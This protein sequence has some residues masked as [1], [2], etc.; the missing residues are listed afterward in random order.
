MADNAMETRYRQTWS[1][2]ISMAMPL[3][4]SLCMLPK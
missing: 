3:D 4:C 2:V 1:G